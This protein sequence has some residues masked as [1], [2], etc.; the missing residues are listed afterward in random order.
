MA[1][2]AS[3]TLFLNR[4]T[5]ANASTETARTDWPVLVAVAGF[6]RKSTMLRPNAAPLRE[7]ARSPMIRESA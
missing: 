2:I 3:S 4:A 6:F 7:P 5:G 1:R